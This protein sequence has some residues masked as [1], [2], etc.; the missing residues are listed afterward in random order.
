LWV[1]VDS[2]GWVPVPVISRAP[3][4]IAVCEASSGVALGREFVLDKG[5]PG[6]RPR[7]EEHGL[8]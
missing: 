7:K 6:Y 2:M 8:T 3:R 5:T 1:A 4:G